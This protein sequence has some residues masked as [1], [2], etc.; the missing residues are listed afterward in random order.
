M[1]Q[2]IERALREYRTGAII[3]IAR[4]ICKVYTVEVLDEGGEMIG[5]LVVVLSPDKEVIQVCETIKNIE[6]CSR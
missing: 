4:G 6:L 5:S 1:I 3:E 2:E